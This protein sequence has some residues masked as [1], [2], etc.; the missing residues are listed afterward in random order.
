LHFAGGSFGV[1][2]PYIV[3]MLTGGPIGWMSAGICT[4]YMELDLV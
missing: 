4:P 2:A 3:G 1:I